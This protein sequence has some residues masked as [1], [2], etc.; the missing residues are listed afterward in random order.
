ME[1]TP[2]EKE[3]LS[4]FDRTDFKN[5]SK[6]ELIGY[7]S[8]LSELRPEVAKEV[9]AQFPELA[10]LI[11]STATEYKG[12]LETI[13]ASD[14]ESIK[15]V[16]GI[17]DKE[18]DSASDSRKEYSQLASQ[19]LGDLSKGLADPNLSEEEKSKI[20]EQEIEVLKMVDK[21]D[22]EIREQEKEIAD[23]A[24]KKDS[25]KRN[26]NWKAIGVASM[27]TITVVGIGAAALGGNFNVKLPK[28]S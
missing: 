15:Q 18:L 26:F 7:A 8:K 19:V 21:K 17:L 11:Q 3:V 27:F 10:K 5:I 25:E 12:M 6:N 4:L 14:N 9:I 2:V 23:T 22:S 1:Y 13:I 24:D 20:R 16:Y 28:K